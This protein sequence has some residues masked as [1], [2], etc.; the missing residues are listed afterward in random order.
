MSNSSVSIH[1][2]PTATLTVLSDGGINYTKKQTF[3]SA[4]VFVNY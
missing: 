4:R 1:Q 2:L 3:Q